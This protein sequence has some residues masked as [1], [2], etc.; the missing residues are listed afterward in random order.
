MIDN[1]IFDI[2]NVLASFTWDNYLHQTL[3]DP[4]VIKKTNDAIRGHG[5]W[6]EFDRGVMSTEEIIEGFISYAPDCEKEIRMLCEHLG[7][8]MGH[9]EYSIPWI[10]SIKETGRHVF[11]LSN[12][13]RII[14]F[15]NP[16][17]FDFMPL[18]EGG[19]LSCDVHLLKPD[20][21]IYACLCDKYNLEPSRCVF[22]DDMEANVKAA[23]DFGMSAIH[24]QSHEQASAELDALLKA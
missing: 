18:M 12:Y 4:E 1:V 21:A 20:R 13:S 9:C 3:S 23:R 5:L 14:L 15:D 19:V 22:L 2:G 6:D 17:V 11:Y 10:K 16:G 7:R 8:S 24:V